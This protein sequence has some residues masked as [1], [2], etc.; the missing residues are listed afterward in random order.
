MNQTKNFILIFCIFIIIILAFLFLFTYSKLIKFQ[1]Q[2]INDNQTIERLSEINDKYFNSFQHQFETESSYIDTDVL[3]IKFNG[4]IVKLGNLIGGTPKLILRYTEY[5]C[6]AC[7]IEEIKRLNELSNIIGKN[8]IIILSS[9]SNDRD[10]IIFS[11]YYKV[12]PTIYNI[13]NEK[14]KLNPSKHQRPYLFILD[15]DLIIKNLFFPLKELPKLSALY[16][17]AV[18]TRYFSFLKN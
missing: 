6:Q 9:Y 14:L 11:K 4:D 5:E 2:N 10:A 13:S 16:Y 15:N 18:V 12:L 7:V 3:L 1:K 8:N 17:N